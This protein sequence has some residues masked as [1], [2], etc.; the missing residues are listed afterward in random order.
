M[1]RGYIRLGL[2]RAMWTENHA[3][4]VWHF[5]RAMSSLSLAVKS[6]AEHRGEL[7]VYAPAEDQSAENKGA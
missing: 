2:L 6:H 3:G 5:R 4:S 7:F 1:E